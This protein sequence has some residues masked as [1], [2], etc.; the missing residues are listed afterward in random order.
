MIPIVAFYLLRD[1]DNLVARVR[2]LVPRRWLPTV[3]TL[4]GETDQV[5]AA[6]IR[7][8]LSVMAALAVI[9]S[10]GLWIAGLDLALLIGLL[11][12]LVSFV[13]YLGFIVGILAASL[14]VL[15]QTH[16]LLPLVWIL[17]VFG[18]GQMLESMWLTPWLV[19]NQIGL[20]PVIVI[21][22]ILAGGQLF[23]FV[24]VLLA[25]PAAAVL[26]VLARHALR[27]WLNSR[28]YL[29]DAAPPAVATD[30]SPE[31]SSGPIP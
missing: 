30:S 22:A 10:L 7:G 20:H 15:V 28:L 3:T 8:Q 21:F 11:A 26:A 19:G 23:G 12:G 6:F 13:P 29:E 5:L 16:E 18:A 9:Y 2:D 17:L 27:H 31:Q 1:W 4:A 24:G 25:L 14:A